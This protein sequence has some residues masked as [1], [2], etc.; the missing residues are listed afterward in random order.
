MRR[1]SS[2]SNPIVTR[3]REVARGRGPSDLILLD[4]EHLVDEALMSGVAIDD[5]SGAAVARP[6]DVAGAG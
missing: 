1:I 2:R 3:F 5:D 4:G 6:C